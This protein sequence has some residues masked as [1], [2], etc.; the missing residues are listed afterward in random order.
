MIITKTSSYSYGLYQT[1]THELRH[2]YQYAAIGN[3]GVYGYE[4][5]YTEPA[6]V[7]QLWLENIYNYKTPDRDGYETYATQPIEWDARDFAGQTQ[8][9]QMQKS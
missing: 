4:S 3:H 8:A 9:G 5:P 1:V 7:I 2:A 6:S